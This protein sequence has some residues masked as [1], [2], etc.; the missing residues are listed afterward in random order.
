MKKRFRLSALGLAFRRHRAP[1]TAWCRTMCRFWIGS[2]A[3]LAGL[4]LQTARADNNWDGDG[5]GPF[6]W[7]DTVNWGFNTAPAYGTLNFSGALGTTNTLD[8]STN[9]NQI[10]WNGTSAWVMNSSGGAVLNLFDNGGVQ[11]K[12][13]NFGTGGV[14]INAPITF[15][16]TT[17]ANWGE[18]NAVNS[19]ITFGSAGPLT[20]NGSGVAGIR[21]FGGTGGIAT[22]FDNTV[23]A[24]GKYFSTSSVGQK[25]NIGGAFTATDFYL[26]N[27]GTLN[28]NSGGSLGATSIRLGGDFT[29]TGTQNLALGATLNLTAMAG[30][31]THTGTINAVGGN[32]SGS[33]V[34]NSQNTSGTNT[35]SGTLFLDSA[36]AVNQTAG[37]TLSIGALGNQQA[38]TFNG[39][40]INIAGASSGRSAA[41]ALTTV[42]SGI[43]SVQNSTALGTSGTANSIPVNVSGGAT[44]EV[45]GSGIVLDNGLITTLNNG[46]TLRSDGSNTLNG[47][48]QIPTAIGANTI[49]VSTV[50]SADVL[51]LGNAANDLSGGDG[52]DDV[53][54]LTGP[55]TVV[56]G[57]SSDYVGAWNVN[58]GTLQFGTVASLGSSPS[59]GNTIALSNGA[60]LAYTGATAD[61]GVNRSIAIGAGGGAL[62]LRSATAST[63]TLS[64]NLTGSAPLNF[65][66]TLAGSGTFALTGTNS[67]YTGAI[68]VDSLGA[69]VTVLNLANAAAIPAASSITL[70]YPLVAAGGNGNTLNLAGLALPVGTTLNMNSLGASNLRTS[71]TSSGTASI[72]GP[73]TIAGSG[74]SQLV[75]GAGSTLTVNGPVTAGGGGFTGTIFLRGAG[76]GILNSTITVPTAGVTKT[77]GGTWTLNSTGNT[78]LATGIGVGTLRMGTANAL[79]GAAILTLGQNDTSGASL[80]LNG[81]SQT[82]GGLTTNPPNLTVPANVNSKTVTSATAATLTINQASDLTYAGL[83]NGG[84]SLVKT[85]SG[86]LTILNTTST[87]T[88]GISVD[89]AGSVLAYAGQGTADPTVLGS[90]AKLITLTNGGALRPTSTSNPNSSTKSVV[91]GTGGGRLDVPTGVTLT[92]DDGNVSGA[93]TNSAQLQGSG[94]LTKSGPGLLQLG[95]SGQPAG[96]FSGYTGNIIISG[97]TIQ[98]GNS[99]AL[100][101]GAGSTT[102]VQSGGAL[103]FISSVGTFADDIFISGAGPAAAGALLNSST[104]NQTL[105]GTLT[106]TGSSSIGATN[107]GTLTINGLVSGTGFDLTKLGT[108]AGVVTLTHP[109]NTYTG[110]TTITAGTLAGTSIGNVGAGNTSFGNVTT[111][112]GGT[113]AIGS[114]G[115]GVLQVNA[116]TASTTD[117]VI[118]LA[119]T[120]FNGG[121]ASSGTAPVSFTSNLTVT[122]NGIKQFTLGGTNTEDNTFSGIIPDGGAATGLDKSGSGT[123]VLPAGTANTYTGT[124]NVTGGVLSVNNAASL[125]STTGGTVQSGTSEIR[126]SGGIIIGAEALSLSGGG[127]NNLGALRN[128]SGDNTW[129]GPITLAVISRVNSDSGTLTI[130]N[131]ITGVNAGFV[132][133]GAGNLTLNGALNLGTGAFNKSDGTGTLTLNANSSHTGVSTIS[134]GRLLLGPGGNFTGVTAATIAGGA[135]LAIGQNANATTNT[136]GGSLT[137]SA[138]SALTMADGFTST[139]AVTGATTFGG[140]GSSTLN[141]DLGGTAADRI[142]ST[143]IAT[144]SAAGETISISPVGATAPTPGAYNLITGGAGSALATNP[145]ALSTTKVYFAGTPFTLSLANTATAVDLNVAAF[146]GLDTAYWKG[147]LSG[148]WNDLSAG[149]NWDT[150]QAGAIDAAAIPTAVTDVYI[151]ATGAA[152]LSNTLGQDFTINSL[153]YTA[154]STASTVGA[155]NTLTLSA[156]GAGNIGINVAAGAAAHA[157]N[158]NIALAQNQTWNNSSAN[159]LTI[160]GGITGAGVLTKTGTGAVALAGSYAGHT[161]GLVVNGGKIILTG[162]YNTAGGQV[163]LGNTAGTGLL[164]INGGSLTVTRGATPAVSIGN[165]SGGVGAMNMSS[166]ALNITSELWLGTAAGGYGAYT[167]TG[168]SANI[169]SWLALGRGG[170]G[171]LNVGGGTLNVLKDN[172]TIGTASTGPVNTLGN[173]NNVA[174]FGGSSVTNVFGGGLLLPE[175][176][177]GHVAVA[178][179]SG[180]ATLNLAGNLSF[181]SGGAQVNT[182]IFNLNGGTLTTK[183]I[184]KGTGTGNYIFNFNGGT[185]RAQTG[186]NAAFL[187]GLTSAYVNSGGAIFDTNG[188]NLSVGQAL[189]APTGNGVTATGLTIGGANSGYIDTPIVSITGGGGGTG[190]T[191]V[192]NID[193]ATG[194]VTGITITNPGNGYTSAPTFALIGGGGA[195]TVGGSA[196]LVANNTTGGLTKNG[197]GILDLAAA[198]TYTGPTVVN[199]G[200]LT[201]G[202]TYATSGFTFAAGTSFGFTNAVNLA[203]PQN[204]VTTT[205]LTKAGNGYTTLTGTNSF[206]G[207]SINNGGGLIFNSAASLGT[208]AGRSIVDNGSIAF[209]YATSLQDH[210]ICSIDGISGGSIGLT[211]LNSATEN[212]DFSPAGGAN[213]TALSLGAANGQAISYTGTITP[214]AGNYRLGGSGGVLTLPNTNALTGTNRLIFNGQSGGDVVLTGTND[215]TGGTT[216]AGGTGNYNLVFSNGS[217][218]SGPINFAGPSTLRWAAGNTQDISAGRTISINGT[219]FLDTNGNNVVL[220]NPI[221][222]FGA[223]SITKVGAGNLTLS[224]INTYTGQTLVNT[225]SVILANGARLSSNVNLGVANGLVLAGTSATVGGILGTVGNALPTGS[226]LTLNTLNGAQS[227]SGVLSGTAGITKWGAQTQTFSGANTYTAATTIQMGNL[228]NAGPVVSTGQLVPSVLNLSFATANQ[229]NR[230]APTSALVLGGSTAN[231][232]LAILGGGT[233]SL[234]GVATSNNAQTFASTTLGVGGNNIVFANNATA[235]NIQL[236]LGAI[237]RNAGSTLHITPSSLALAANNGVFT[238]SGTNG[239]IL[240][241]AAGTAYA[242]I[243]ANAAGAYGWAGKNA[244]GYL[245]AAA[246]TYAPVVT[247]AATFTA[248]GATGNAD[249]TTGFTATAGTGVGTIRMNAA[250]AQN[251]NLGGGISTISTG[252]VLFGSTAVQTISTGTLKPGAGNELVFINTNTGVPAI[253]AILADGASASSVTYRS[254]LIPSTTVS[255]VTTTFG[256]FNVTGTNTYTGPTYITSGRVQTGATAQPFGTGAGAKVFI[257]G[258]TNGQWFASG[259]VTVANP[260]VITGNGWAEPGTAAVGLPLGAI[261]IDNGI[262]LSGGVNLHGDAAIGTFAGASTISG[263]VSGAFNLTKLGSGLLNLTGT[264][265]LTGKYVAQGGQLTFGSAGAYGS[266]T[267]I[268]L[269]GGAVG[270]STITGIQANLIDRLTPL[271]ATTPLNGTIGVSAATVAENVNFNSPTVDMSNVYF[272]SVGFALTYTGT[273]TPYDNAYKIGGAGNL[274]TFGNTN[275]FTDNGLIPRSVTMRTNSVVLSSPNNYSGGTTISSATLQFA[276]GALGSGPINMAGGTLAW[277]IGGNTQ[278]I[279]AGGRAVSVTA[280]ST[281]DT[282]GNNV[283]LSGP[284][285]FNT[286]GTLTKAGGGVLTLSGSSTAT[287][288]SPTVL[289][290]VAGLTLATANALPIYSNLNNA[291]TTGVITT[292]NADQSIGSLGGTGG[293]P[294]AATFAIGANTLTTGYNNANASTDS[295]FTG[296][297]AIIKVGTGLQQLRVQSPAFT[298]S[299]T[300]NNGHSVMDFGVLTSNV[301]NILPATTNVTLGGGGFLVLG[302]D[303]ASSTHKQ[304]LSNNITLN[305]GA[306][307][308][309]TQPRAAA[310]SVTALAINGF[311]RNAG[312]T[313]NV[314]PLGGFI[315]ATAGTLGSVTTNQ[316]N[317]DYTS[318]GGNQSILAGYAA[319]NGASAATTPTTWAVSANAASNTTITGLTTFSPTYTAGTNVDSATGNVSTGPAALTVNSLRLNTAG[320]YAVDAANGLS[321]ASGGILTTANVGG[322]PLA[323]LNGTLTSGNNTDLIFHQYAAG[324]LTIGSQITGSIS[325]TKSGSGRLILANAANTYTGTTYVNAGTL[326]YGVSTTPAST[327]ALVHYGGTIELI[328]G[329]TVTG[330]TANLSG[331][332]LGANGALYGLTGTSTWAGNVVIG[333]IETRLGAA[334]VATLNVTGNISDGTPTNG[335]LNNRLWLNGTSGTGTIGL[336]GTN[337]YTGPT[338]IIRGIVK[339]GSAGALP[340]TTILDVHSGGPNFGTTTD[341]STIDLNGFS[342]TVAG[343]ARTDTTG[344]GTITNFAAG[345]STLTLN[346]PIANTF[347][348]NIADGLGKVAFIKSGAGSLTLSGNNTFTG[349]ITHNAGTILMGSANAIGNQ[350]QPNAYTLNGGTL[351]SRGIAEIN[352]ASLNG[353]GGTITDTGLTIGTTTLNTAGSGSDSFAGLIADGPVRNLAYTKSGTGTQSLTNIA[354]TYSG[355]TVVHGGILNAAALA[356]VNTASSIGKGSAAGSAADLLLIGGGTL[357]YTGSTAQSTNRLLTVGTGGG[358]AGSADAAAAA[359]VSFTGTGSIAYSGTSTRSLTLTGSNTGSNTFAPII[360][361]NGAS[362]AS[363]TKTGT[364]TWSLTGANTYTGNT[365]ISAGTLKLGAAGVLPDTSPVVLSGGTLLTGGFTEIAGSLSLTASSTIDLSGTSKLTFS[366]ITPGTLNAN[367]LTIW[368]WSGNLTG[369]GLEGLYVPS[370]TS[371]TS[372]QLANVQFLD[373]AGLAP[374][375]YGAEFLGSGELVPVP[376]PTALGAAFG[377][378]AAALRRRRRNAA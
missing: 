330:Q 178:N 187:T 200:G 196:T 362:T 172:I 291:L 62:S 107:T 6:N 99:N 238:S 89:G 260:F 243:G 268:S 357:Q 360:G 230:I 307:T 78:W 297:G 296:S 189:L 184:N 368:N 323:I 219:S 292:L 342:P 92:L 152:N 48:V 13:E 31:L 231:D 121:V 73:I 82:I 213:Q 26:M 68:S 117:R 173:T 358:G 134:T 240:T 324:D 226:T 310:S 75:P 345:T 118:D 256:Q 19:S 170:N 86:V 284:L 154:A 101:S 352:L 7:S 1:A 221:G 374:G 74:L 50:N 316:S 155:G 16:A 269:T 302:R 53:I 65:N 133:G 171:V 286:T 27:S 198:N 199:A 306:S 98:A 289:N 115:N 314:Y 69:G 111:A 228:S 95:F 235:N 46:A 361:N 202:N 10:Q 280:A 22:T 193:Y 212:L 299:L 210:L 165:T 100:G 161:G 35:L 108:G 135:T 77:D 214:N 201:I 34:I 257:D 258:N 234:T 21:M 112:P 176:L 272:G 329:V 211:T 206:G 106:L 249:V 245:D 174:N 83:I 181:G 163:S 85:G 308:V 197:P 91:I 261:R 190:A 218:G 264:N 37:G 126:L 144:I 148:L 349:G 326:R 24:A 96:G 94:D 376:E 18:I 331:S 132:S 270:L 244:L 366:G 303:I 220:S 348:G 304:T 28:V 371:F 167:Q 43:L 56:S 217:L 185:L 242:T 109:A 93:G 312:A 114:V 105:N 265:T 38:V 192:A 337:T 54:N 36:L 136:L 159:T 113:I 351:D 363:L 341:Q 248:V 103:D 309:A 370:T 186:S 266:A 143:G 338:S 369:A 207:L 255:N 311:T 52:T 259:A 378:V 254:L 76:T 313:V 293:T 275:A 71:V 57:A 122:G 151:N 318:A 203:V 191:A 250:T 67:G 4:A 224:G 223:S 61:L 150:T 129:G 139:L 294:G 125:G 346:N 194:V 317:A 164:N 49:T 355:V 295:I 262:T 215:Y 15:A 162:A 17:G 276:N 44:L 166:G 33:L 263:P 290:S 229:T 277:A 241:S 320:T 156:A 328:D 195:A 279:T 216:L 343:L 140:T 70:N 285:A 81:F 146:T 253:S 40:I 282:F 239:A 367:I 372:G 47:R 335:V 51:T 14:T 274:M 319:F 209:N 130:A 208:V 102:T 267:G 205:P 283:T 142:N 180:T 137:L 128:F 237:T 160:G 305:P 131:T 29:T 301:D 79:P 168:G 110:L 39:G 59:P 12:V 246:V 158:A 9:M 298:G 315:T 64:G 20:V 325:L 127:N 72:E 147:D 300:V 153:N 87:F 104:F 365:T 183:Q 359:T 141:F 225:G 373:P 32:T 175:Q 58:T 30:G 3:G 63:L 281:F 333:D 288:A 8:T 339:L 2:V 55:G 347:S 232:S 80:D 5:S 204:L 353:T 271:N 327:S 90:G 145:F 45:K 344:T 23:S 138:G 149:S 88:G 124:T 84:I 356:N 364:G 377:A 41:S 332:G 120:T 222:N 97:G 123:W 236:N 334:N 116:A 273:I 233:L 60:R 354:N 188:Q 251:L 227:Y 321:I 350:A 179:L 169:G 11:A 177:A 247:S 336:S 182:G 252:G 157:F 25:V 375:T 66:S 287:V 278:D 42:A 119:G 322:N 340:A